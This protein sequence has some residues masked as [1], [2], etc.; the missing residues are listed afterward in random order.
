M[1]FLLVSDFTIDSIAGLMQGDD[2]DTT[3]MMV[4]VAPLGHV[5]P[6]LL[7]L[8]QGP[9]CEHADA[10]LIWTR[11]ETAI[12]GFARVLDA[13]VTVNDLR[14]EVDAF[15][16]HVLAAAEKVDLILVPTW[17][18]APFTRGLGPL[19]MRPGSVLDTP[20]HQ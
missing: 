17:T 20:S 15:A 5:L 16:E 7:T 8:A 9:K 14:A 3:T 13:P 11:P 6:S 1:R 4:E 19:H 10:A 18:I 12:P 2:R